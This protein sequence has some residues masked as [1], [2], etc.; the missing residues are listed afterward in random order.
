MTYN[1]NLLD[2]MT[3]FVSV[4]DEGG[5]SAAGRKLRH[6]TSHISKVIQSLETR[7]NTRLLNRTT[8]S[9]SLTDEGQ[10]YYETVSVIVDM[11]KDMTDGLQDNKVVPSGRLRITAPVS[12][13]LGHLVNSLPE[14]MNLYPDIQVELELN[15]RKVDIVSQGYDLAIRIGQLDDSSL[16]ARKIGESYGVIIASPDYWDLHGRPSRPSD[17]TDHRCLTY[18]NMA[19]PNIWHF[20]KG[21]KDNIKVKIKPVAA[22][23]NAEM[24]MALA[25]AGV[26]VTRLP[27]FVCETY[28]KN[29]QLEPV[30]KDYQSDPMAIHIVYANRSHLPAKIRAFVDFMGTN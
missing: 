19:N 2:G 29:G 27:A 26:G 28:L 12:F 22:C 8:R 25:L 4:V 16:I 15:D 10:K 30:L 14:F 6:S 13:A 18:S 20:S 9:I 24:E 21:G 23:N 1:S 3:I 17:L 11:A 7:L 5:F